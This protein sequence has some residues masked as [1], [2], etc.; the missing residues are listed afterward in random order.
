MSD[1]F[2]DVGDFEEP[3]PNVGRWLDANP[4]YGIHVA[5]TL[6]AQLTASGAA[7]GKKLHTQLGKLGHDASDKWGSWI[8]DLV[9]EAL[10]NNLPNNM[11]KTDLETS[12]DPEDEIWDDTLIEAEMDATSYFFYGLMPYVIAATFSLS[13][14][15]DWGF[16]ESIAEF[17]REKYPNIPE[18]PKA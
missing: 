12:E 17:V 1:E 6:R 11:D 3:I 15:L 4:Q 18:L 9:A 5:E 13:E 2:G 8:M 14:G 10:K 7:L 16:P